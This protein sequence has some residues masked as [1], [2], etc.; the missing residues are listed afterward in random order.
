MLEG[1]II[2]YEVAARVGAA[3]GREYYRIWHTTS[4]AGAFGASTALSYI[5][6][7][8]LEDTLNAVSNAGWFSNVLWAS[9]SKNSYFK[10]FSPAHSSLI[11]ALSIEMILEG[12]KT[13]IDIFEDEEGLCRALSSNCNL[14]ILLNPRWKYAILLNG[15]KLYPACRHTHTI[16]KASINLSNKIN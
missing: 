16:I 9:I 8:S 13:N 15:Y 3:L 1:I 4:I 6:D 12:F 10:S 5:L 11:S 2:G 14:D 7:M